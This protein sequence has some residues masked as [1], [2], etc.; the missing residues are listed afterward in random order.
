[1]GIKREN[2]T[3]VKK[4]HA[5]GVQYV[6]CICPNLPMQEEMEKLHDVSKTNDSTEA[7]QMIKRKDRDVSFVEAVEKMRLHWL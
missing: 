3:L 1:M 4:M 2:V 5:D 6:Q 7:E